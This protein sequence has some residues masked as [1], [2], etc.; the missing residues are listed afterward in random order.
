MDSRINDYVEKIGSH[1]KWKNYRV[2]VKTELQNHITDSVADLVE[3]GA[4][5]EEAV[6]LTLKNMGDPDILG[7][8][9]NEAYKPQ[10]NNKLIFAVY[11][12][13]FIFS[14]L[15]YFAIL[16]AAGEYLYLG[17]SLLGILLG[18]LGAVL[19]FVSD[20]SSADKFNAFTAKAYCGVMLLCI[21]LH[22]MNIS[23]KARVI[24]EI[25]LLEPLL[26]CCCIDRV[27]G[28]KTGGLL[29]ILLIF[30]LPLWIAYHIQAY[31]GIMIMAVDTWIIL[32]LTIK[33]TWLGIGRKK[34]WYALV[35]LPCIAALL[36]TVAMKWDNI[37]NSA[38]AFFV[39]DVIKKSKLIG[40]GN[41]AAFDNKGMLD[42]PMTFLIANYGYLFLVLYIAFFI[43]LL[44]EIVKIYKRQQIFLVQLML[45]CVLVTFIMEF[46]LSVLLN[47]GMPLAKGITVPFL[48]FD[49]GIVIK[50]I[51]LGFIIKLDCFGNYIFSN[52]SD[53][54]LFDIDG[55][56]IIIYYK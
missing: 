9:L 22:F 17:K 47:L 40:N 11:V 45:L 13:V 46:V 52:Y 7:R 16:R 50:F 43:F 6:S 29:M 31:A 49:L 36:Y 15:A 35:S 28:R 54:K 18:S 55:E 23:N 4:V 19:L 8:Q 39:K 53:N 21:V 51:Q 34:L 27:K 3:K 48:D 44:C 24:N 14:L 56:K 26:C 37:L 5:E 25:L 41:T 12:S 38:N 32:I 2:P 33:S 42:Y 10:Y 30:M 1:I 20:W